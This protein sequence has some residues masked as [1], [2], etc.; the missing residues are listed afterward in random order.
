VICRIW[1]A[2]ATPVGATAYREHFSKRVLPELRRIDGFACAYLLERQRDGEVEVL[3]MTLWESLDAV[4]AFAGTD[5]EAAVV[6]P[7][8][9]AVLAR[10]DT[11]VSHHTVV[12]DTMSGQGGS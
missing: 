6:E 4:R 2:T 11:V 5:I 8:A 10:Y 12:V 7:E 1:R 3:V 9:R